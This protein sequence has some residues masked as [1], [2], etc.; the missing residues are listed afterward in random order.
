MKSIRDM[1]IHN[2]LILALVVLTLIPMIVTSILTYYHSKNAFED[3]ISSYSEQLVKGSAEKINGELKYLE[4]IAEELSM[5]DVI[6]NSLINMNKSDYLKSL[7][8]KNT[9]FQKFV[10]KM[11]ISTLSLSS[12]ITSINIILDDNSIIGVGHNNYD[13]HQLYNMYHLALNSN[14]RFNYKIISDLNGYLQIAMGMNITNNKTGENIGVML[15]TFKESY[16][17]DTILNL[18]LGHKTDLLVVNEEGIIVSTNRPD[19]FE[20]GFIFHDVPLLEKIFKLNNDNQYITP[21]L[22]EK[23]KYL[24]V[25]H[26]IKSSKWHI[27]SLIPLDFVQQ[28]STTLM[29][30]IIGIGLICILF[31]LPV[32]FRISDSIEKPILKLRKQM[33]LATEGD[34]NVEIEDYT[35]GTDEISEMTNSFNTMIMSIRELIRENNDENKEIIYKLGEIIEAKSKETGNHVYRVAHFSK[36]IGMKLGLN[37]FEAETLKTASI[38]HDIGKI[39]I[40]DDILLKPGKLTKEEFEIIKTHTTI[41]YKILEKSKKK[42]LIMAA[43]IALEHHERYDGKGYPYGYAMDEISIHSRIVALADVF[44]ALSSKRSYKEAWAMDRILAYV[45]EQRG[46]Q[47]DQNVVDA[48]F[49][50][51]SEIIE[52]K[53]TFGD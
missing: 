5:E 11:R 45:E 42:T 53:E 52:I 29:W 32:A 3:K 31:S 48:F 28:E 18:D 23:N 17:S 38:L 40:S 20:E 19:K 6:Q 46:H 8:I 13:P 49:E 12:D 22:Y 39:G 36:I 51:L 37:E 15:I 1:K 35:N 24:S 30:F 41:G 14:D 2:R 47:F 34:L 25:S 50:C 16:I 33:I 44:D 27:I 21:I 4:S 9:I 10:E 43:T 7:K 26:T